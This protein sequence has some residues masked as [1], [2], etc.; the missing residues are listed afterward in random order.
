MGRKKKSAGLGDTIEKITEVTGI[1]AVVEKFSEATGLD[2]GCD[3][4][5]ETLN[6][7]FP[8]HKPNC[9]VKED[10]DYLTTF[11]AKNLNQLTVNDQYRLIDVYFRVFNK[12]IE[13]SNC[14]SCWRERIN[15]LKKVYN[16]YEG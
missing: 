3:A 7:L 8:Y 5:K 4:R 2:C 14:G 10:Y 13:H 11:F 15:E 6:K 12:K 1:K 9:L 16:E